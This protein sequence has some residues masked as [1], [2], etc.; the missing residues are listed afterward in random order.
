MLGG[1]RL[2][3][4]YFI[5]TVADRLLDIKFAPPAEIPVSTAVNDLL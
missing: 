4:I 5:L 2:L 1:D 3:R